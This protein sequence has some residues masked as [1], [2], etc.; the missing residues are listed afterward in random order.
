[1]RGKPVLK[2]LWFVVLCGK[3]AFIQGMLNRVSFRCGLDIH[4]RHRRGGTPGAAWGAVAP[5]ITTVARTGT[6]TTLVALSKGTT[7]ASI[8]R[9]LFAPRQQLDALHA[10]IPGTITHDL[11]IYCSRNFKKFQ[12]IS[13]CTNNSNKLLYLLYLIVLNY[14]FYFKVSLNLISLRMWR[15]E[16]AYYKACTTVSLFFYAQ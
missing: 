12:K 7:G 6:G 3:G 16:N 4:E 9:A 5:A 11:F 15:H 2:V 1:M 8:H 10:S 13:P 14:L